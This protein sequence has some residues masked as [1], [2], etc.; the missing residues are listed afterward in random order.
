MRMAPKRSFDLS[1]KQ[2]QLL[3]ALERLDD[4]VSA[5]KADELFASLSQEK[6]E[7]LLVGNALLRRL[8]SFIRR[9]PRD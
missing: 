7:E 8:V 2:P 9:F 5:T 1:K 4:W 6:R 3:N